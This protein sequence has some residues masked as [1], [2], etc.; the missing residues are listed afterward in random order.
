[1]KDISDEPGS[2]FDAEHRH[3]LKQLEFLR[4][5]SKRLSKAVMPDD[6]VL[7]YL[8]TQAIADFL[9][10]EATRPLDGIIYPSV[11]IGADTPSRSPFPTTRCFPAGS[12]SSMTDLTSST[13]FG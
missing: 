8:P 13:S 1:M 4:G 3:R 6:Q 12:I 10:T 11:Q 5:L 2:L 7:D 9:A